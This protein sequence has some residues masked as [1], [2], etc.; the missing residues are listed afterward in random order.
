MAQQCLL[1]SRH[2]LQ[3]F[4]RSR[5]P[6]ASQLSYQATRPPWQAQRYASTQ[7]GQ[8]S[9]DPN[10]DPGPNQPEDEEGGKKGRNKPRINPTIWKM[11]ESAATTFASISILGLAGYSYHLY[12]KSMVLRKIDEAFTPG[13]PMLDLA[14]PPPINKVKVLGEEAETVD[15]EGDD[16]ILRPEQAKIDEIILGARTGRYYLIVGEKGTGKS[17]MILD[18][19]RKNNGEGVSMFEGHADLEIF[20]VRLGKALNYDFHEDCKL[21]VPLSR[22]D[23]HTLLTSPRYRLPLLYPRTPRHHRPSR[24]RASIQQSRKD[25][26]QTPEHRSEEPQRHQSWAFSDC[27]KQ[28]AFNQRR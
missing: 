9:I 3:H 13:D 28:H 12:Y 11:L 24:H 10:V 4:G 14:A 19:M 7:Y 20:R 2:T 21:G 16:W 6:I 18:A 22:R 5:G 17:T 23:H 15:I 26:S 25:R 8:T 27:R 1:R